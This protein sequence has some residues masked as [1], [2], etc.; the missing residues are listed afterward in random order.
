MEREGG[1]GERIRKWRKGEE[2]EREWGHIE[3]RSLS[4]SSFSLHFLLISSFSLH[5]LFISSIF[6]HLL[7]ARLQGWSGLCNPA[8]THKKTPTQIQTQI[9]YEFLNWFSQ[10]S[11]QSV[12][13][14]RAWDF[15]LSTEHEPIKYTLRSNCCSPWIFATLFFFATIL[16]LLI[17]LKIRYSHK[18]GGLW[19]RWS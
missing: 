15:P 11:N 3:S 19:W 14:W 2:M 17:I 16:S 8:Q 13:F 1:N 12:L 10:H 4:I 7:A 18:E 9:R 5:F 6:L